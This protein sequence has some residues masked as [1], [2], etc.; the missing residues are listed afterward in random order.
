MR[1]K[2]F[3]YSLIVAISLS[4]NVALANC[5]ID[6][7]KF[8][9]SSKDIAKLLPK[10]SYQIFN[11]INNYHKIFNSHLVAICPNEEA[12]LI[13]DTNVKFVFIRDKLV[14]IEL[15]RQSNNDLKLFEWARTRYGILETRRLDKNEQVIQID[16]GDRMIQLFIGVLPE[17][18]F[19]NVVL[20]SKNHADLFELLGRKEDSIDWDTYQFPEPELPL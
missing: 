8:G 6:N 9:S 3:I 14:V 4:M 1:F 15:I 12:S 2:L 18:V 20:I 5:G 13:Q 11:R 19:Q 16:Y 7:Y 10:G 17:A